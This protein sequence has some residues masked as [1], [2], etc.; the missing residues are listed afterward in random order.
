MV[1]DAQIR[2]RDGM[3]ISGGLLLT[4][5]VAAI[6]YAE[7]IRAKSDFCPDGSWVLISGTCY[8]IW[9]LLLPLLLIGIGLVAVG[10]TAFRG[11]PQRLEQHLHHG[12]G[13]HF[14]LALLIS[15]VVLPLVLLIIQV[16]REGILGTV[17]VVEAYGVPY[18]HTFLLSIAVVIALLM[19]LPYFVGFLAD[20]VRRRRF[21]EAATNQEPVPADEPMEPPEYDEPADDWPGSREAPADASIDELLDEPAVTVP[22]PEPAPSPAPA[23]SPEA[24]PVAAP[25][26]GHYSG[27]DGKSRD[28]EELEGIGPQ[29]AAALREAGVR[30]TKR[31]CSEDAD[32]LARQSGISAKHIAA[33]QSMAELTLVKG[34]GPQYAEAIV[35]A[36][37]DGIAE[38]KRRS[39]SRIAKQINDYLGGLDNN[40]LGTGITEARVNGWKEAA[41]GM[42]KKRMIVPKD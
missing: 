35:R 25:D 4:Y 14:L 27:Y 31:L 41:K 17:F 1:R 39:A 42:R 26:A 6:V 10:L 37:I 3:V 11:R 34:I 22:A 8:T 12:T 15:L 18:K 28:V 38:L 16:Y 19:F 23:P 36:G 30:T 7:G 24:A 32:A 33:W 13:S 9:K 21:L 2:K 40:V 20:G 29:Y 5:C